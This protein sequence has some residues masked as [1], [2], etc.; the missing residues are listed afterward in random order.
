MDKLIV[1]SAQQQMRLFDST[2]S[3]RKELTRFL[4]MA[5]AKE[6]AL[7][8]FPALTG[9]MA[10]SHQVEGFRMSLLKRAETPAR[11]RTS[12]WKRTRSALAG[13][14][15]SLLGANFRRAFEQLLQADPGTLADDYQEVF[16]E[17][18]RAYEMT[19]V[20]GSAYLPDAG[21]AIRHRA[22]VFGPDGAVLG[23]HDKMALS[24]EDEGLAAP[25]DLWHVISTPVGRLG[26]L[27]G[28]EAL[29]PEAG[30]VLAYQ[31]ADLLVTLAATGSEALAAYIRQ[32]TLAQAQENRICALTSFLVGRNFLAA[33]DSLAWSF[34]G[35]SGI[36]APLEMTPRYSGVLVEM[37][38]LEA[39][40]LITAEL[41]YGRLHRLWEEGHAPVRRRMP[42][43]LF[44]RYLPALYSSH[45]TLADVWGEGADE[46]APAAGPLPPAPAEGAPVEAAFEEAPV[47]AGLTDETWV[48]ALA[49]DEMLDETL[50]D[51]TAPDEALPEAIAPDETLME[52]TAADEAPAEATAGVE[53]P[54][55]EA[56]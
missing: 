33:D 23:Y 11:G 3:Y 10:A 50:M 48:E 8:V 46:P 38:A 9:V 28:E 18:A 51:A 41:D 42:M 24:Q 47:E 25:G 19:I 30:R 4:A 44:A 35:K 53:P 21:G 43:D 2:E 1:A 20:A 27:L 37:G 7:V 31:G 13:G 45:R 15:A 32:G 14:T 34:V 49:P 5:R 36:Y 12:L 17:L 40:G 6:A 52:T 29:Y 54:A 22:T 16:G 55:D 56:S 26:I 39:E